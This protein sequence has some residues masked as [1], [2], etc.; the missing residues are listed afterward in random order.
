MRKLI[1]M[2]VC[3]FLIVVSGFLVSCGSGTNNL[4]GGQIQS[5]DN[6]SSQLEDEKV[7]ILNYLSLE[8]V[9]LTKKLTKAALLKKNDK[10]AYFIKGMILSKA[11]TRVYGLTVKVT[12]YSANGTPRKNLFFDVV[13][14][15]DDGPNDLGGFNKNCGVYHFEEMLEETTAD[16]YVDSFHAE[17][18]S[19][20]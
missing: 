7:N 11:E 6:Q 16:D 13:F 20:N 19:T 2:F 17:I 9:T 14:P 1:L 18:I 5:G 3:A 12:F 10:Y 15:N 8:D 4:S